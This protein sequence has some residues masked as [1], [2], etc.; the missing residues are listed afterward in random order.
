ERAT[1]EVAR[2]TSG[3][4][5]RLVAGGAAVEDVKLPP[6]FEATFAAAYLI[7]RSDTTSI[8][9]E[10]YAEKADLYRPLIRASIEVGMLI[11]GELYVRALRIRG[12][13]RRE[14]R[15]ALARYDVLA[16]PT[17]PTPAPEGTATGDP[18]FQ[19]P[20]SLSGF[21][22]ITVPCGMSA[23]GLPLGLQ[24]VSD[25]FPEAPLPAAAGWCEEVLGRASAP[26]L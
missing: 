2:V 8:H 6:S 4:V 11:P 18:R 22:S 12:Q 21:P 20:W 7:T 14:L 19:V 15:P 25:T 5:D 17:T 13:F 10:R 3:A 1:A 16:T 9:A 23:S 26:P 24:L